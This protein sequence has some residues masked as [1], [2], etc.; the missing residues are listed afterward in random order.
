MVLLQRNANINNGTPP[1][2]ASQSPNFDFDPALMVE[3]IMAV[4]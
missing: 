1:K 3:A 4:A 2:S